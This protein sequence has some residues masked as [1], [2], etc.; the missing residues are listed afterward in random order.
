MNCETSEVDRI[1]PTRRPE[2]SAAGT[3]RW[4]ELL[5]MHWPVPVEAMRAVVPDGLELD[6]WEGQAWVGV[7]PFAMEGVKPWWAPEL[8]AFSFLETNVR[9]Y[10]L[11]DN[12]PGVYFLSLDAAST[13]AVE[14]ARWRWS[15]PYF[16]AQMSLEHQD[17]G[18]LYES[19]RTQGGRADLQVRYEL[20]E[21]LGASQP[22]TLEH[23]FLERYLLFT[24]R[25]GEILRGQV[26]HTPYPAQR[27]QV[28]SVQESLVQATGLPATV[29]PP[30]LV[31]YAS[32][33]DVEVF[34]LE[35]SP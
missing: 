32:G 15:L 19:H 33:V 20:G 24:Q 6:L 10:V 14:V 16:R 23:F 28:L 25:Q 5:F 9:T 8:V 18:V 12:E 2:G 31:H 35:V 21:H 13:I 3:Q 22:G 17:G 7:V 30:A 11:R 34:D 26:Y 4:R 1:A 27:A 29:G